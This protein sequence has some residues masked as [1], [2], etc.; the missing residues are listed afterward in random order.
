MG[1]KQFTR[2]GSILI[3]VILLLSINVL[4]GYC[5]EKDD[6]PAV[7][8]GKFAGYRIAEQN[9]FW[10]QDLRSEA[11]KFDDFKVYNV[12]TRK[13]KRLI[14]SNKGYFQLELDAGK[15]QVRRRNSQ[16]DARRTGEKYRI[17]S[18]FEVAG[19]QVVNLGTFNIL[20][21]EVNVLGEQISTSYMIQ[22]CEESG[23]Y[24]DPVEWFEEKKPELFEENR[25]IICPFPHAPGN[26]LYRESIGPRVRM[27]EL[28]GVS[29]GWTADLLRM[30]YDN[31]GRKIHRVARD[32]QVFYF[33]PE[34]LSDLCGTESQ[35][36]VYI[37]KNDQVL[38]IYIN[39]KNLGMEATVSEQFDRY[40]SISDRIT[41]S[42]G[43]KNSEI[44]KEKKPE[45]RLKD[46]VKGKNHYMREWS[47]DN[48]RVVLELGN[49]KADKKDRDTLYLWA[50]YVPAL[51]Q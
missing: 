1:G 20:T 25:E 2:L 8:L 17:Y 12:E 32:D 45:E 10:D 49:K 9:Q 47:Y 36:V 34:M 33:S 22:H 40:N 24:R 19:D 43:E 42:L 48:Y 23:C 39:M 30:E 5:D 26:A 21:S 38:Q 44:F 18:E 29:P 13:K 7:V 31:S 51:L 46:L 15:Y 35:N 50:Y 16:L 41:A 37:I 6:R 27:T 4:P 11:I 28:F 3:A 14:F